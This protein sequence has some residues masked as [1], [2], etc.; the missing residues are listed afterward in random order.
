MALYA[1]DLPPHWLKWIFSYLLID[2]SGG[3]KSSL[4][5]NWPYHNAENSGHEL[6]R[7]SIEFLLGLIYD[8]LWSQNASEDYLDTWQR[9][10]K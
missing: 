8:M 7:N 2:H 4:T 1:A 10:I 5:P 3:V 6:M 9:T